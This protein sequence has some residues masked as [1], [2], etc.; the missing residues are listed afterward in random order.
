ML[1]AVSPV[2]FVG[3]QRE[4]MRPWIFHRLT[5]V[6][7]EHGGHPDIRR[8]LVT[9]HIA[10]HF[11]A[12]HRRQAVP[13][14]LDFGRRRQQR[15]RPGRTGAFVAAGRNAGQLR[16]DLGEEPA[17]MS[18]ATEKFGGE[19]TDMGGFDVFGREAGFRQTAV[20]RFP[21]HVDQLQPLARPVALEVGLMATENEHRGC[22][23]LLLRKTSALSPR[24]ATVSPIVQVTAGHESATPAPG[25]G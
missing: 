5:L 19:I 10:H 1:Q 8:S 2:V 15:E 18:L 14:G 16:V 9:G 6:A 17:Q 21:E 20:E 25:G 11:D 22:H 7:A 3:N 23:G 4:N 24:I 12:H 13:P